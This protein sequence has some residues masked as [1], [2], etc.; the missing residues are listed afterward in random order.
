MTCEIRPIFAVGTNRWK[1]GGACPLCPPLMELFPR[2]MACGAQNDRPLP[3]DS[4]GCIP[5]RLKVNASITNPGAVY[6]SSEIARRS[7][8]CAAIRGLESRFPTPVRWVG[9]VHTLE[10][11]SP[12]YCVVQTLNFR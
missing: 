9:R 7:A 10:P 6:R 3:A 12:H 8:S 4:C 11:L 1:T 2:R 5:T